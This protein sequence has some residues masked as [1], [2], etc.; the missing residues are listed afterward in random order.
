MAVEVRRPFALDGGHAVLGIVQD[1]PLIALPITFGPHE[2]DWWL[3]GL[4]AGSVAVSGLLGWL[5]YWNGRRAT[6]IAQDASDRESD[7]RRTQ[8]RIL[9]EKDRAAIALAMSVAI[10]AQGQRPPLRDKGTERENQEA[11]LAKQSHLDAIALINLAGPHDPER[12]LR[13]WYLAVVRD[14]QRTNRFEEGGLRLYEEKRQDALNKI[15]DWNS[16]LLAAGELS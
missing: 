4:S 6:K 15:A 5:A 3:V 16:G 11:F 2:A 8:A 7:Y 1:M 12:R 13:S 9:S 14:L 10:N